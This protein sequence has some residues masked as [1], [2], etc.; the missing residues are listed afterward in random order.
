MKLRKYYRWMKVTDDGLLYRP[1]NWNGYDTIE[2]AE[3]RLLLLGKDVQYKDFI[4]MTFYE[5]EE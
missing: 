3:E 5:V 4:L 2:E 1:Y